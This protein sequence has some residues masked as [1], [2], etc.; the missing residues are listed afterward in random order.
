MNFF[1][2]SFYHTSL[3]LHQTLKQQNIQETSFPELE[4]LYDNDKFWKQL[5]QS[6]DA[7]K[8]KH[9]FHIWVKN[10]SSTMFGW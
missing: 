7:A 10:I 5:W 9:H 3:A 4:Y 8:V 1:N 2:S 6:I